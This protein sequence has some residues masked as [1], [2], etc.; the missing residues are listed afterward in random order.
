MSVSTLSNANTEGT[1]ARIIGLEK[2][3]FDSFILEV[4]LRLGQVEGGMVR[5]RVPRYSQPESP[6]VISIALLYQ[7]VKK[8][9]LSVDMLAD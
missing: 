4:A 5:R 1:Y 3:N 2:S 6:V 9:I 7:L 8:V